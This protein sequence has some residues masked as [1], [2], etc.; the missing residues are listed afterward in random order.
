MRQRLTGL[1]GDVTPRE[2]HVMEPSGKNQRGPR[3]KPQDSESR[4]EQGVQKH[5]N[6]SQGKPLFI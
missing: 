4:I 5:Q 3:T 1:P 2:F 6:I